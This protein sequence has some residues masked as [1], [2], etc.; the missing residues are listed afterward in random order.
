MHITLILCTYNRGPILSQ[1]LSSIAASTL[2]PSVEWEVLVVDNNSSDQTREIVEDFCRQHPAHFRYLFEPRAGKSHALQTGI[3]EAPGDV[4]AFTD[5]DVTVE[6]TW[7]QNLTAE[8]YGGEWAGAGGRTVLQWPSSI[9]EWLAIEGP[10]ARHGLPGFDQGHESKQ[11][12][13]PPFGANMA[14]RKEMFAKHGVFRTDLGPSPNRDIPRPNEDTEFGRRL[15]AAGERLRY[16]PSA[17]VYHPVPENR[18]EKKHLLEWWFDTG[19]AQAREFQVRP[20][21]ALCNLVAW[22]LR[23]LVAPDPQ[24]RFF[25]RLVVRERLGEISEFFRQSLGT[26]GRKKIGIQ[27][28]KQEG[29]I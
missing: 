6:P 23:G 1:T 14:F 15:I 25:S 3:R 13:G 19:R 12:I 20:V 5:D 21:R 16:E 29:N 11:L 24:L 26:K 28:T 17:V 4:V 22:K 7:L 2:P 8:L 10:W 18:M 9:P 27:K